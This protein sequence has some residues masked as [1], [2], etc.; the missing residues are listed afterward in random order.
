MKKTEGGIGLPR[1]SRENATADAFRLH[2]DGKESDSGVFIRIPERPTEPWMPVN[3]SLEVEIGDWP[4]DYSYTGVLY[5]FT[6]A[7]ARPIRTLG[8]WNRMEITMDGA[9]LSAGATIIY[10]SMI[11]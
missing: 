10:C 3:R 6:K 4:D 2:A 8:E 5:M 9:A 7:M 11:W 1:Y